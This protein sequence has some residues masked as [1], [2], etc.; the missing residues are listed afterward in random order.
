VQKAADEALD[1]DWKDDELFES[2]RRELKRLITSL[3]PHRVAAARRRTGDALAIDLVQSPL[4]F[5]HPTPLGLAFG[6]AAPVLDADD[7]L[8]ESVSEYRA[9]SNEAEAKAAR[10]EPVDALRYE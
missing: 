7:P 3:R 10:M 5:I 4:G 9:V 8:S 1:V 2:K 6:D